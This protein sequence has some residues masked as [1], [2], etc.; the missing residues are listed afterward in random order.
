M[1]QPDATE[2]LAL[3]REIHL[4]EPLPEPPL[5]PTALAIAMIALAITVLVAKIARRHSWATQA[6]TELRQIERSPQSAAPLQ[7]A[8]LLRRIAL[9]LDPDPRVRSLSG[10]AWL[11]HLNGLFNTGFFTTPEGRFCGGPLYSKPADKTAG[12]LPYRQLHKL[13]KRRGRQS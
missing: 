4:P 11:E 2:L 3:L 10:D 5:W 1:D 7:T 6:S 9:T 13:I 12:A 8:K